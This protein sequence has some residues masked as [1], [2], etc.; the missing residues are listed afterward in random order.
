MLPEPSVLPLRSALAALAILGLLGVLTVL[1]IVEGPDDPRSERLAPTPVFPHSPRGAVRFLADLRYYLGNRYALRDQFIETNSAIKLLLFDHADYPEVLV[2][3]DGFLFL[4]TEGTVPLTQ[5][6]IPLAEAEAEGWRAS[7]ASQAEG[8]SAVGIPYLFILAPMKHTI[9]PDKLPEWLRPG[10][11]PGRRTD[12]ILAIA[13]DELDL[14]VVDLRE[15]LAQARKLNPDQLLYH[16]TDTHWNELGAA[17]AMQA[18]LA[19]VGRRT[20]MPGTHML[21]TEYG[22]DLARMLGR[23]PQT[24]EQAPTLDRA[25]WECRKPDGTLIEIVTLDALTPRRFSCS[26]AGGQNVHV[27]AFI[28]SFGV[29]AIPFLAKNFNLVDVYWQ[30]RPDPALAAREGAD[31]VLNVLVERRLQTMDPKTMRPDAVP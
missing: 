18:V 13:R 31:L 29:P 5:G 27:V 16:R 7:F 6:A 20:A 21:A 3:R 2:G 10:S 23:Q 24:S 19:A 28:D 9:Y 12:R 11:G 30:N 17:L 4:A 8:F 22:G 15:T 25:G 1:D 26:G 14:P